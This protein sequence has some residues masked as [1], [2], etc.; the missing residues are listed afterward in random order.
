M[1]YSRAPNAQLSF[2]ENYQAHI[3]MLT[4]K[5]E[6]LVSSGDNER[7]K[8]ALIAEIKA[9]FNCHTPLRDCYD[10]TDEVLGAT[11]LPIACVALSA[12]LASLALKELLHT[13]A[14]KINLVNDDHNSRHGEEAKIKGLFALALALTSVASLIKCTLSLIIRPIAT[15]GDALFHSTEHPQ[16]Q[17]ETDGENRFLFN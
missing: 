8:E 10:L 2:F 16:Q 14:I 15:L 3:T 6:K 5:H 11:L 13:I 12:Y 1:Q 7:N 4:K 9:K 17:G